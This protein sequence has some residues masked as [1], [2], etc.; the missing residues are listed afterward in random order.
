MAEQNDNFRLP[1]PEPVSEVPPSGGETKQYSC[2]E[3]KSMEDFNAHKNDRLVLEFLTNRSAS[4]KLKAELKPF[5]QKYGN[6][7]KVT[8]A[9]ID[10]NSQ[11]AEELANRFDIPRNMPATA[12]LQEGTLKEK[13]AG[14]HFE[15]LT[16]DQEI[17]HGLSVILPNTSVQQILQDVGIVDANDSVN[18]GTG[19]IIN[20][21]IFQK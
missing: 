2:I 7:G 14:V 9:T 1:L 18:P 11:V 10:T 4:K 8:F 16:N 12:Y 13:H 5:E 20:I 19:S 6:E 3:I 17:A 15:S 21:K